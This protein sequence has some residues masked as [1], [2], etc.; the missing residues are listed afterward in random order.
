MPRCNRLATMSAMDNARLRIEL[1]SDAVFAVAITVL[2]LGLPVNTASG[3]LVGALADRWEAF[4]AFGISFTVIGCIWV[5]HWRMFRQVSRAD[6]VLALVNLAVLLFIVLIPFGASTLATYVIRPG[7]QA[8]IAAALFPAILLAMGLCNGA[9]LTLV[10][11][12]A[13]RAVHV[14]WK[15]RLG[16][17]V[18]VAGNVIAIGTA[19]VAPVGVIAITAAVALYYIGM[20][21]TGAV[22]DRRAGPARPA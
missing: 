4:A 9:L 8:N 22:R 6:E 13:A 16:Q 7:T 17:L 10:E 15:T 12:R 20:E 3:T 21:I 19:F 14:T 11:R 1:F 5:G 2:V 18:G